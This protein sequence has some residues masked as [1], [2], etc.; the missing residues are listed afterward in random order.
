[1]RKLPSA[2]L[3][4]ALL[5][6]QTNA[7][8]QEKFKFGKITSEDFT[9]KSALVDS[10]TSAVIIGDVGSS[11]FVANA[12]EMTFSLLFKEK[13][14]IKIINKNG[15][16]AATISVPLYIGNNG[17]EEELEELDAYTY[18]LENGKVVETKVPKSSI[19]SEKRSKNWV[20]KKF[21][22]P[23]VKE[24]SIIEYSY[25][26]R[27]PFFTNLQ[28]WTFQGEY[29][30]LW[31]Q[32]EAAIPEFFK[33]VTLSQG[34]QAFLIN[35]VKSS[36]MSFSFRERVEREG[37]GMGGNVTSGVNSFN[38]DG[39]IDYHNWAMKNVPAL[40]EEAYTTTVN[41]SVSKLEFQ[42]NQVAYPNSIPQ[43]Y[44]NSWEKVA[45]NLMEDEQF[46]L[47]ISRPNNWLD[48]DVKQIV[49]SASTNTEKAQKIYEHVRDNFTHND[50]YGI[51]QTKNLKDVF[52][53][54]NG[55]IAEI[56]ML[57]IAMLKS[58]NI[59]AN[60]VIL[61]TRSHG[62]T[63]EYYPLMDRYNYVVAKVSLESGDYYLDAT[64]RQLPF[65]MLP[66]RVY[67][68]QAREITKTNASPVYFMADSLKESGNSFI[69]IYNDDN[70]SL[71][72]T[73]TQR[74]G[75][76][77][78]LQIRNKLSTTSQEDFKKSI[79]D[80]YP[81]EIETSNIQIDSL[82]SLKD[83]VGLKVDLKFTSFGE[84]D[85]VYFNPMLTE[86]TSKNPFT[87][88]ERLYPVEMPF[89]SD[90]IYTLTMQIPKGYKVD[91]LP[92]SVRY[93]FNED[94]GMFEYII[95]AD[96]ETISF[97]RRL[98]LNRATFVNEDYGQL[99]EMYSFI[100]KKEAE[101]IVFKKIP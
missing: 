55:S 54:K 42:L 45:T 69:Y 43:N 91:E 73:F 8:A 84:N 13:K 81:E 44:M 97:R 27:S 57:L 46:G 68:G 85:I 25:E 82:K 1:M 21:T 94:E 98:Y 89:T 52:K 20:I 51:Y 22:F 40:K 36:R 96:K 32:Y 80:K 62:F 6:I 18:N 34:Y 47:P 7:L 11:K 2:A 56:N 35:D 67:N 83:P 79:K 9:V 101:Q 12:T 14:R 70:G 92:K 31:S 78:S 23:A 87:A 3:L 30:V 99:R 50:N 33:Y 74:L 17:K 72:G 95:S 10:G 29:P 75:S 59:N 77:E 93:K 5:I 58:K 38:I 49:Q 53:N 48:D 19:F 24:G 86:A 26:V 63:H 37:G 15:F 41:N 90:D 66:L 100:V 28:P 88:A 4:L 60:P 71:Q 64:S 61:S 65:G 39:S 76:F 16:K